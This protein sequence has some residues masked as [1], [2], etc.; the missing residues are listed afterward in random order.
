MSEI[1]PVMAGVMMGLVIS[2][3]AA[4]RWTGWA[5]IF[6]SIICGV[7]TSWIS[8]ELRVTWAYLVID[9][10]Q[11]AIVSLIVSSLG[12]HWPFEAKR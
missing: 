1:F 2:C 5:W 8:T 9:T 10:A 11:V 6:L 4:R 12:V 3:F 7:A